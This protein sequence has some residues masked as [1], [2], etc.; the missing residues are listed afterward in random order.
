MSV[1]INVGWSVEPKVGVEQMTW[2]AECTGEVSSLFRSYPSVQHYWLL[3]DIV[4]VYQTLL[5][6]FFHLLNEVV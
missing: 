3:A 6:I 4:L 2:S 1:C 5:C